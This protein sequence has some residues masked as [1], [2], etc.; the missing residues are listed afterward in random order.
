MT[1]IIL[2]ITL[3]IF[4]NA[5]SSSGGNNQE[6]PKENNV[7]KPTNERTQSESQR[8]G[9]T[10]YRMIISHIDNRA[11]VHINDS[12]IYDSETLYGPVD[13]ELDL[14][15]YVNTGKTDLKVDMYNGKPPYNTSSPGW[16]IVYDLYV[17]DEIVEFVSEGAEDGRIGLVYTES[18]DLSELQ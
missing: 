16:L 3:G 9:E 6:K 11:V 8:S 14:T 1:R 7:A 13:V 4:I 5:C 17:D 2:F 18:H 10:E 15:A 12:V